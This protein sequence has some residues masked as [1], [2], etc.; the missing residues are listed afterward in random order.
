[1]LLSDQ[2]RLLQI[3][4][5]P[6]KPVQLI[7]AGKAHPEDKPGQEMIQ[8]WILF[9]KK[10]DAFD[11]VIFLN[12]YDMLVT[13]QLVQGVD[14]WI[15]TPRRPWEACGTSG[16]KVLVNGGLNLS[17]LDGWWAEAYSP[18]VGWALGDGKEHGDDLSWDL[19][20][21]HQLYDL[22]ENE[23]VP[24]FYSRDSEGIPSKWVAKM[25]ASM[26]RLTPHFSANRAVREYTEKHYIPA[27]E[28]YLERAKEHGMKGKQI[29]EWLH[30]LSQNWGALR[31]GEIKVELNEN[32]YH[33]D[34]EVYLNDLNPDFVKVELYSENGNPPF[35]M[36]MTRVRQLAGISGMY[37]YHASSVPAA[38]PASNYTPR[39]IPY[40][41]G[42][43]VPLEAPQ[44]L[45]Q[46]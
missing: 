12:D 34:V 46:K 14:V 6:Q 4:N 27:A 24:E 7:I 19:V 26:A 3:L 43:A 13:E 2:K 40:Y 1:M 30:T 21:A 44:I 25:R 8:D 16:M 37:V 31:F 11:R 36:E 39:V 5:N 33:F 10:A 41:D 15:N 29:V 9:I 42:I 20:E 22:L 23:V 45:W 32:Q 38:I 35:K 18:E 17:E 28:R